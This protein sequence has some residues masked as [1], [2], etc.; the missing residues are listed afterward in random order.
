MNVEV[1]EMNL[2]LRNSFEGIR[3]HA[4]EL[5]QRRLR[6]AG[7]ESYFRV[8]KH[9]EIVLVDAVVTH[10]RGIS[11]AASYFRVEPDDVDRLI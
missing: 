5:Q 2:S 3:V 1:E 7:V 10:T 6:E 9:L 8:S 4:G 11:Q